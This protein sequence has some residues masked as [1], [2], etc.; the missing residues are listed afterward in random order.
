[1]ALVP[2]LQAGVGDDLT[3]HADDEAGAPARPA[4]RCSAGCKP[5]QAPVRLRPEGHARRGARDRTQELRLAP[6]TVCTTSCSPKPV[7]EAGD[8]A[9]EVELAQSGT[10]LHRGGRPD[11]PRLPDRARAA[12]RCSTAS[13]A[14]AA[15]A[16]CPCWKATI[17]HRG[18]LPDRLARRAAGKVIQIC[19]S[20]A[21]GS[22]WC[23]TL[24]RPARRQPTQDCALRQLPRQ[25]RGAAHWCSP[26]GC[27]ATSTSTRR[28]FALE[29]EHF[30]ANTW[31]YVGHDSQ[32]PKPGDYITADIAG[33]PLIV[34]RHDDG[35]GARADEPLRAQG[36]ARG[37]RA[38]RQHRQ[39]LPLPVPRLDL[40]HRRLA[41][42]HPAEERLRRHRACT[43][44]RPARAWSRCSN[45]RDLSR[46]RL[47][48]SVN[49]AAPASRSTSATR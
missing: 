17:D 3:L 32:M 23:W 47:R 9:F 31:N 19:I 29:Q 4:P 13:A 45:V 43:S 1:M 22:A 8:R 6:A 16:P 48:A 5:S 38:L 10:R 27:T 35:S 18:L 44:A 2:E 11:H 25:A 15:C 28:S 26:T 24:N 20:R 33:Q 34:V 42:Q 12:T 49:D 40:Q 21:K 41:A 30:L 7:A 39:V 36:L 37:Q 14:N 46:L